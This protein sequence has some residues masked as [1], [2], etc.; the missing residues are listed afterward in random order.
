MIIE[1]NKNFA[2]RDV[3]E[4]FSLL[5]P[6]LRMSLEPIGSNKMKS[7][8]SVEINSG[9]RMNEVRELCVDELRMFPTFFRKKNYEWINISKDSALT[10]KEENEIG[11]KESEEFEETRYEDFLENEF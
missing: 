6:Y 1:L 7:S 5:Y 2:I 9:M 4:E 8:G 11:K 3:E 10:L